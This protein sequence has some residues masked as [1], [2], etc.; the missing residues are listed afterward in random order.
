MAE[1]DGANERYH[2]M[3]AAPRRIVKAWKVKKDKLADTLVKLLALFTQGRQV[4]VP[5][6]S[7]EPAR[8]KANVAWP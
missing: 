1:R 5:T 8:L 4:A 7:V 3:L 2:E 6:H